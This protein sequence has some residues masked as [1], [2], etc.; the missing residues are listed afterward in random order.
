[1]KC[2]HH[3]DLDGRCAAAIVLWSLPAFDDRKGSFIEVD[4]KDKIEVEKIGADERVYIVDFSF[5]PEVMEQVL[6]KTQNIIWIDHHKTAFEYDYGIE[7]DGLRN[8]NYSGCELTW[9]YFYGESFE[10]YKDGKQTGMP[11]AIKLIGDYDKW[12]LK[13]QPECFEF[14]EG[15]KLELNYP[16]STVWRNL[17]ANDKGVADIIQGGKTAIKY[18]DNYCADMNKHYG[19][20]TSIEEHRAFAVNL[21]RFGSQGFGNLFDE[22]DLCISYIHD[23]KKFTVS[24]YSQ[25]VDVSK[26]AIK[27]GGGGHTGAAGFVCEELPFKKVGK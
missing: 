18:R 8:I 25:K 13:Y 6:Q 11:E 27:H 19:Y 10:F 15:M 20:E 17:F 14:Y 5:K 4:Y 12:A 2:Y 24:L 26:I 23:G 9:I 7:L 22:Y 1:M 16:K 21:Y 3:N